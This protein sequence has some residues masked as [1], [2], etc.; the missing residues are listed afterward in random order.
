MI[1][2]DTPCTLF[3]GKEYS[4]PLFG[5]VMEMTTKT[6]NG[7]P[8]Y[9]IVLFSFPDDNNYYEKPYIRE[10]M[11]SWKKYL[12]NYRMIFI[13]VKVALPL[14]NWSRQTY[15]RKNYPTDSLR[16]LFVS[17]LDNGMYLDTDVYISSNAKIPFEKDCFVLDSCSGTMLWNKEKNNEKLLKWFDW[18]EH[19]NVENDDR[20]IEKYGDVQ[21]YCNY[22]REFGIESVNGLF[23]VDHFSGIYPYMR[24]KQ[25]VGIGFNLGN[26][27]IAY[28]SIESFYAFGLYTVD[29]GY[30]QYISSEYIDYCPGRNIS[31]YTC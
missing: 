7:E 19:V 8:I 28:F 13:P 20:I 11:S 6:E 25:K 3:D 14:S 31:F 16:V 29:R 22:G 12:K 9:N 24:D 26:G 23:G 10:C 15:H 18:Y 1:L 30:T 4:F 17:H 2:E 27:N 5:E 21:A